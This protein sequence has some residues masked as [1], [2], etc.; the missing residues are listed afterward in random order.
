[1]MK[2]GFLGMMRFENAEKTD[3]I[4]W[5]SENKKDL[6]RNTRSSL[7]AF[8]DGCVRCMIMA[9]YTWLE[10]ALVLIE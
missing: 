1:M 2:M 3:T 7:L 5:R 10:L 9:V 4:Q 6:A 8:L